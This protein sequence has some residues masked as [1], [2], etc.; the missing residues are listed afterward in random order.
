M[1]P[2]D[3]ERRV[4]SEITSSSRTHRIVAAVDALAT[5]PDTT[6]DTTGT[7]NPDTTGSSAGTDSSRGSDTSHTT[8][9]AASSGADTPDAENPT[10]LGL[11]RN[12]VAA[13]SYSLTFVTGLAF[14][15]L[16]DDEFVRFH[17]AQSTITFGSLFSASLVLSLLDAIVAAVSP[18]ASTVVS[19]TATLVAV[20][21]VGLWLGLMIRASQ[22]NRTALPLVGRVVEGYL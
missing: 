1:W 21:T 8:S 14:Y 10:V 19:A 15:V 3:H 12:F 5:D 18:A 4:A 7:T 22:G 13:M 17:A 20:L 2:L 6:T 11:S 16:E 9:D